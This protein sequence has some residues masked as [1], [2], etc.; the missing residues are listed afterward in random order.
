MANYIL[1]ADC[2]KKSWK[3]VRQRTISSMSWDK[4]DTQCGIWPSNLSRMRKKKM[5]RKTKADGRSEM[6]ERT[7]STDVRQLCGL[8]IK[9][10][11]RWYT[12]VMPSL[13]AGKRTELNS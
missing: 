10:N 11:C 4:K 2:D 6:E 13:Q 1:T 12:S 3:P 8:W 7:V 5:F 9:P